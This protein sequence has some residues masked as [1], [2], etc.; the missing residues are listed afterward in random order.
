MGAHAC[1]TTSS[2]G[3]EKS[4]APGAVSRWARRNPA[5]V[6]SGH[7]TRGQEQLRSHG[8]TLAGMQNTYVAEQGPAC[9]FGETQK[10]RSL[11][12]VGCVQAERRRIDAAVFKVLSYRIAQLDVL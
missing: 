4:V 7:P 9:C 1:G 11:P 12:F 8:N 2:D 5:G 10:P 3:A 6:T